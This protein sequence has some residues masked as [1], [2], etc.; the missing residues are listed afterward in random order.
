MNKK[1]PPGYADLKEK[2]DNPDSSLYGD[3]VIWKELIKKSKED[4]KDMIFITDDQ[5]E[6]WFLQK[7]GKKYGARPELRAEFYKATNNHNIYVCSM[8]TFISQS[9][10][11]FEAKVEE[12]KLRSLANIIMDYDLIKKEKVEHEKNKD[13]YYQIFDKKYE[14]IS[15]N[16]ISLIEA[17]ELLD[18]SHKIYFDLWNKESS[19]TKNN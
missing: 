17:K 8:N 1:I 7:D 6:D 14:E 18:K 13:I 16:G 10:H 2:K 5:K 19:D 15:K 4:N 12:Q 3:F 11:F 9:N